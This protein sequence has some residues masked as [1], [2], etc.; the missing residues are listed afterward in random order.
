MDDNTPPLGA[1]LRIA[2]TKAGLSVRE[3]ERLTGVANSY[4]TKLE[5]NQKTNPSADVLQRLADVLELDASELLAYIGVKPSSSLPSARVYF[6]KKYGLSATDADQ[7][8][9]RIEEY[10]ND[11]KD[12]DT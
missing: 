1:Y 9:H 5:L 11:T 6:R 3:L 2:R 12:K 4:L 8:L 7:V 10:L